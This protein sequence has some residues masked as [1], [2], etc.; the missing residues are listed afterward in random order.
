M[1]ATVLIVGVGRFGAHYVRI[2]SGLDTRRWPQ[3]PAVDRLVVTRTQ[4][5]NADAL[6]EKVRRDTHCRVSEVHGSAIADTTELASALESFR[7]DLTCITGTDP[8]IGDALHAMYTQTVLEKSRSRVLSEKPLC[9]AAGDGA[10]LKA[11]GRIR[12]AGG[13]GRFGLELPMAVLRQRIEA[14]PVLARRLNT[15]R[16]LDFFWSTTSP[17]RESLVDTLAVHP[18]SLIPRHL[19]PERLERTGTPDRIDIRGQ[20]VNRND[21]SRIELAITL[22]SGQNSRWMAVDGR[23]WIV[24]SDGARVTVFVEAQGAESPGEEISPTHGS[25]PTVVVDNPLAENIFASLAGMPVTGLSATEE[26]QRF[27]EMVNGWA[28][29]G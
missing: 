13:D 6:A 22:A 27:L 25:P 17:L 1:G 21:A 28:D 23:R 2:L 12:E 15:A 20:L 19:F 5:H 10:S 16:R 24:E 9:P 14:H 18:W 8:S 29:N 26:V 7:P 11:V 4:R 3:V